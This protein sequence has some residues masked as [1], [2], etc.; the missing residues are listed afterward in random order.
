M[1]P[2]DRIPPTYLNRRYAAT[3][4]D[5]RVSNVSM[6][7]NSPAVTSWKIVA[8]MFPIDNI[9]LNTSPIV[10]QT[11]PYYTVRLQQRLKHITYSHQLIRKQVSNE[12]HNLIKLKLQLH[13]LHKLM[14]EFLN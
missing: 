5:W 3:A 9:H 12:V 7:H 6:V 2:I 11:F 13:Q 1:S 4:S 8:Q 10:A 14:K